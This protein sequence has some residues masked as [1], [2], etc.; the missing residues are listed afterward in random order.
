MFKANFDHFPAKV[1]EPPLLAEST[2]FVIKLAEDEAE[3]KKALRLRYEVFNLEQGKGLDAARENGID[4][5]E[6]DPYCLHLLVVS[7][8][9][10]RPVGT[11]RIHLGLVASNAI[12]FYSSREFDL[13]GIDQVAAR[14]MELGRSCTAPDFRSGSAVALLWG[15]I[16]ELMM[17]ASLRYMAGCVSLDATDPAIAWAIHEQLRQGGKLCDFINAIPNPEFKLERP[18]QAEIQRYLDD[19]RE[20]RSHMPPLL[21]GY[22]RLGGEIC[23]EPAIDREFGTIDF[24]IIVDSEKVPERYSRHYN[25][26]YEG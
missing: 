12:G 18:P 16:G 22:L 21:K 2:Q 9:S 6:Y 8:D 25:Y 1:I 19:P 11:Y 23:G 4:V 26:Q 13:V 24:F 7:K 3:I 20:L 5:D 14:V 15:G 17:R 10:L